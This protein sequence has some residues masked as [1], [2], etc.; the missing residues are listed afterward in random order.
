MKKNNDD[1]WFRQYDVSFFVACCL[2]SLVVCLFVSGVNVWFD[3][4]SVEECQWD[5]QQ[6]ID[7]DEDE[8]ENENENEDDGNRSS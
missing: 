6:T 2:S 3:V 1:N 8:D 4:I 5:T 7:E